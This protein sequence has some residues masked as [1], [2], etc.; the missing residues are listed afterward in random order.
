MKYYLKIKV[1]EKKWLIIKKNL[2][3]I[4]KIIKFK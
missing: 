3:K 2:K 4:M 1:N